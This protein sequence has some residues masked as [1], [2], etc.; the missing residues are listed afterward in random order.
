MIRSLLRFSLLAACAVIGM[1]HAQVPTP[2]PTALPPTA[3]PAPAIEDTDREYIDAEMQRED[4]P[5][6]DTGL[7]APDA[8]A[9]D[10][11]REV[12]DEDNRTVNEA[13][14]PITDALSA[15]DEIEGPVGDVDQT[16]DPLPMPV[17]GDLGLGADDLDFLPMGEV[18]PDEI[19]DPG[20][21]FPEDLFPSDFAPPPPPAVTE[22]RAER[23]RKLRVRFQEV[24]TEALKDSAVRNLK[25]QAD[26][27]PTDER[28]RAALR[29]HYRLLFAKMV[30]IDP[31]LEDR[32]AK[33][34][35]AYI[36]RLTQFRVEP[37]I[38]LTP[39][40]T[41]EPLDTL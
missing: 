21:L 31:E 3:T 11:A 15:A 33:M 22:N 16:D 4:T 32:C 12:T 36:R 5:I 30:S 26:R 6:A 19:P 2:M 34:E 40:P 10:T 28:K 27:A 23:E 1:A 8:L 13:P 7:P 39:P 20:N 9:N 14:A 35:E 37:T 41:P 24:R 25:D 38:P 17:D 29:E 18:S